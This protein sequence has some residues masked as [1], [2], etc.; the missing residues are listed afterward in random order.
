ML[1]SSPGWQV[2]TMD[3][4]DIG[5]AIFWILAEYPNSIL[6][7]PMK[8]S[9]ALVAATAARPNEVWTLEEDIAHGIDRRLNTHDHSALKVRSDRLNR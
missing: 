2:G 5:S 7:S 6:P 4:K 3:P 8:F 9:F 1:L